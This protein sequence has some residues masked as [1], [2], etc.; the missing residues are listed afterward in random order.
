[1]KNEIIVE[2]II[3][4]AIVSAIICVFIPLKTRNKNED[5]QCCKNNL[6]NVNT[7]DN[8]ACKFYWQTCKFDV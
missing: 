7:V 2:S 3:S 4:G 1:M 5:W 6:Q 8:N